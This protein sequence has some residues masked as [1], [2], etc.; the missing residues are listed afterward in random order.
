MTDLRLHKDAV[1]AFC[2]G[3]LP[4]REEAE[5]ALQVA[6]IYTCEPAL[7]NHTVS[8]MGKLTRHLGGG[9]K[10]LDWMG[11]FPGEPSLVAADVRLADLLGALSARPAVIDAI[12]RIRRHRQTDR[13]LG[14]DPLAPYWAPSTDSVTLS[15]L[16]ETVKHMLRKDDGRGAI[17]V[18]GRVLE[19][20][21]EAFGD[22]ERSGSDVRRAREYVERIRADLEQAESSTSPTQTGLVTS[23]GR[24]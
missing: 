24:S 11:R 10:V 14:P 17:D 2:A 13:R 7:P 20:L 19:L 8:L 6:R 3:R 23:G 15:D 1:E 22:L 9:E 16:A 12:D 21:D 18:S 4:Y 5:L